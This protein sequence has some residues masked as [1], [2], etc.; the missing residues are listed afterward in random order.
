MSLI[1]AFVWLSIDDFGV[2]VAI[3]LGG[4]NSGQTSIKYYDLACDV[5][6][7]RL[8]NCKDLTMKLE[9]KYLFPTS[10]SGANFY[11]YQLHEGLGMRKILAHGIR[12]QNNPQTRVDF[13]WIFMDFYRFMRV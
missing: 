8:K 13:F 5:K 11:I 3:L 4:A 2:S 7:P 9:V 12:M 6:P 10:S 1:I